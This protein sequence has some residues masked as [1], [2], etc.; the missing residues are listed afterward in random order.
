MI[1]SI[2]T[3]LLGLLFLSSCNDEPQLNPSEPEPEEEEVIVVRDLSIDNVR[4]LIPIALL[5]SAERAIYVNVDGDRKSFRVDVSMRDLARSHADQ[6]YIAETVDVVYIDSTDTDYSI[7]VTASANYQPDDQI[8]E[9]IL[10]TIV[11]S[12][13]QDAYAA[14]FSF[15]VDDLGHRTLFADEVTL[16]DITFEDVYH[17][18]I[19]DSIEAYSALYYTSELGIVGFVDRNAVLW[20]LEGLE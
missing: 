11:P 13:S 3:I 2:F 20:R 5:S 19:L 12:A 10:G 4:D 9:Y 6:S 17:N 7:Y 1:K 15:D 18:R 14:G 16:H 8:S